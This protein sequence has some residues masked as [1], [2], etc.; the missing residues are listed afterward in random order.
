TARS[1]A[2]A[3]TV[4]IATTSDFAQPVTTF[5]TG[6]DQTSARFTP[7]APVTYY[8]R[9]RADTT[10]TAAFGVGE[11]SVIEDAL[12][13]YCAMGADCSGGA[14]RE[15]GD[16]TFPFR[17]VARAITS[18]RA[19]GIATIA[20]A[21]R[22]AASYTDIVAPPGGMTLRGGFD[23]SFDS[24]TRSVAAN[25]TSVRAV[26]TVLVIGAVTSPVTID[27]MHFIADLA[28]GVPAG[29]Q[30]LT[31][32]S[33]NGATASVTFSACRLETAAGPDKATGLAVTTAGS[34]TVHLTQASSVVVGAPLSSSTGVIVNVGSSA[35]LDAGS[36][37]DVAP[38]SGDS[39]DE[40][41]IGVAVTNDGRFTARNAVM[42]AGP[43]TLS[44]VVFAAGG[45][46][47]VEDSILEIPA[48]NHGPLIWSF[49]FGPTTLRVRNNR[50]SC[51]ECA[52]PSIAVFLTDPGGLLDAE[53]VN[54]L[55]LVD[56]SVPTGLAL[57]HMTGLPRVA[58][59]HNTVVSGAPS[60]A[61]V[62]I[63]GSPVVTNNLFVCGNGGTGINEQSSAFI[64]DPAS[65]EGNTLVGCGS[66]YRNE[67]DAAIL[68][69]GA[70]I[71]A[72]NGGEIAAA[73]CSGC[74]HSRY[75]ANVVSGI[76]PSA[77][78]TSGVGSDGHLDVAAAF[79]P[80]V[81]ASADAGGGKSTSGTDCGALEAPVACGDVD[82]DFAGATRGAPPTRGA[83]EAP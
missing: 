45:E 42:R 37:V 32:A 46:V 80:S 61:M 29:A 65:F 38:P 75:G 3:Y 16:R 52:A 82:D 68:T 81:S 83:V 13:V 36:S 50:L 2:S 71:N 55:I 74:Q 15:V 39:D 26:G 77:F 27:G 7:S 23:A 25:P 63:A 10:T 40:A 17:S 21:G 53:L 72:L 5:E 43:R 69:T 19:D 11:F 78:F 18:A 59:V 66:P 28:P 35:T 54:N 48:G 30:Q 58:L 73:T 1:G 8:W 47:D 56:G 60:T 9:V 24:A 57:I 41:C 22:G 6:R 20:V 79:V 64:T 62:Q 34:G 31:S 67:S 49:P 14:G 12:H 76:T 4:E 51:P 44:A 70:A 33:V